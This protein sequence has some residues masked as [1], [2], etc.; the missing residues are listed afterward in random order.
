MEDGGVHHHHDEEDAEQRHELAHERDQRAPA[1]G[2]HPRSFA[3]PGEL[4]ADRVAAGD[5]RDDVQ[6]GR[7]DGPQQE[8]G[9]VQRRVRQDILLGDKRARLVAAAVRLARQRSGRRGDRAGYGRSRVVAGGEILPVVQGDD[10][11]P[12]PGEEIVL[13]V[14]R[15][16]DSRNRV[17]GANSLHGAPHVARPLGDCHAWRGS[18][19]LHVNERSRGAVGVDNGDPKVANDRIAERERQ[20]GEGED[21]NQDGQ[22]ERD[23]V[24]LHPA[25]LARG[26]EKQSGLWRRPH[27]RSAVGH[28][29]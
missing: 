1:G 18:D 8:L 29:A 16:V 28:S 5:R 14:F 12:L 17:A 24:A 6:H 15:D 23:P 26:D 25:Q 2:A 11:R 21:R 9:E 7:Q 10:L 22:H 4:R 27:L 20:D 13:E 3:S 19:R